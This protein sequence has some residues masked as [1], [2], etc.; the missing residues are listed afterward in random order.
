MKKEQK[1]DKYQISCNSKSFSKTDL[2][3]NNLVKIKDQNESVIISFLDGNSTAYTGSE[4]F[5]S[6]RLKKNNKKL[7]GG[8]IITLPV[9][10]GS[11]DWKSDY[12]FLFKNEMIQIEY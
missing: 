9:Q 7:S 5:N 3:L 11:M 12:I 4:S 10:V 1:K 8:A 6:F 2:N